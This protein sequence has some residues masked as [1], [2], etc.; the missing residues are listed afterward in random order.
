MIALLQKMFVMKKSFE[1]LGIYMNAEIKMP[2]STLVEC[3]VG[4]WGITGVPDI[5]GLLETYQSYVRDVI[6]TGCYV[7]ANED[8]SSG[9]SVDP[10]Q[11]SLL[12]ESLVRLT[13][14]RVDVESRVGYLRDTMASTVNMIGDVMEQSMSVAQE[15]RAFA[16]VKASGC[17]QSVLNFT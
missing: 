9:I 16:E 12:D 1:Q 13:A 4:K 6:Q 2:F 10:E 7:Y 17:L 5:A 14:L 15:E 11:R 8:F 3:D